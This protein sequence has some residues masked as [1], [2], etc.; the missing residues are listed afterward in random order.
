MG[1]CWFRWVQS[2]SRWHPFTTPTNCFPGMLTESWCFPL[3]SSV[4]QDLIMTLPVNKSLSI[5]QPSPTCG[6]LKN[7]LKS[8]QIYEQIM[9]YTRYA[10]YYR[11]AALVL[12]LRP[13]IIPASLTTSLS[14]QIYRIHTRE[15][16]PFYTFNWSW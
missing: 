8:T 9:L 10:S 1:F 2:Q 15:S 14:M 12:T 7:V 6:N 4:L 3:N 16:M 5:C 11:N 13:R